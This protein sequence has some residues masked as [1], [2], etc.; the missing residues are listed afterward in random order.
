MSQAEFKITYIYLHII[1]KLNDFDQKT[2][3]V[4]V[5]QHKGSPD[6]QSL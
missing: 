5:K 2:L 1:C 3:L 6:F 4:Y